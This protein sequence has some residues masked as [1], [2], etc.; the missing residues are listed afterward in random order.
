M[1]CRC[2]TFL[3]FMPH[4]H[5]HFE[6]HYSRKF[7]VS[8]LEEGTTDN[9][10]CK[11]Y[12]QANLI[13]VQL[14]CG[15]KAK[16]WG[17]GKIICEVRCSVTALGWN[18]DR[19]KIRCCKCGLPTQPGWWCHYVLTPAGITLPNCTLQSVSGAC[20]WMSKVIYKMDNRKSKGGG[21]KV[22]IKTGKALQTDVP[23][24]AGLR[25]ETL[26]LKMK[27]GKT[28]NLIY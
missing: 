5:S 4:L 1:R 14:F 6:N 8:I 15:V 12:W 24:H 19:L 7:S 3:P 21:E 20:R 11:M 2:N 9:N 13:N 16:M 23:A 22:R 25:H 10:K 18:V 27:N 17:S 28:A 26:E